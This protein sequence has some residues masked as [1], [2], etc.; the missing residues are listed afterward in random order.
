[1]SW[2]SLGNHEYEVDERNR[3]TGWYRCVGGRL[4]S[5][6]WPA[7]HPRTREVRYII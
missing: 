1:M 7:W 3:P 6:L 2:H 4:A 5:G